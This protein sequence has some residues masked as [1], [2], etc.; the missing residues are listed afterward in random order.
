M[1]NEVILIWRV[2]GNINDIKM[3]PL[4]A[5]AIHNPAEVEEA[6]EEVESEEDKWLESPTWS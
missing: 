6:L 4:S 5:V 2:N 3:E 1:V